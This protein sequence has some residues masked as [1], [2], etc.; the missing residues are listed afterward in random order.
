M[1][2]RLWKRL[3]QIVQVVTLALFLALFAYANAQRPQHFWTD[4]FT[5]SV[6]SYPF[7]RYGVIYGGPPP[8]APGTSFTLTLVH[9]GFTERQVARGIDAFY[10]K[11]DN[12][13]AY[14]YGLVPEFD[15]MNNVAGPVDPHPGLSYRLYLPLMVRQ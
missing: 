4:V 6:A 11:L 14:A 15:E 1:S 7:E 5:A 12:D 3:R 2:P 10:V 13:G 8:L 9:D